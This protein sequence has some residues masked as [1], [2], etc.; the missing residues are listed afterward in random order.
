M[1]NIYFGFRVNAAEREMIH[2]LA[3]HLQ[4]KEADA[5]RYM[6]RTAAQSLSDAAERPQEGDHD[7]AN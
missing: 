4:R 3:R 7:H 5:I 2:Q 1:R 6:V